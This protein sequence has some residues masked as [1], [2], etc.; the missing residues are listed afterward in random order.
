MFI[1]E[2]M[3][4]MKEILEP[5]LKLVKNGTCPDCD[6]VTFVKTKYHLV[7]NY[8]INIS[9][10]LML[11]AKGLSTQSHP[12]IKRLG[13]YRQLLGQ[14]QSGEENLLKEVAAIV[15]AVKEDKPLYS[16]SDGSQRSIKKK[17]SRSDSLSKLLI[18]QKE[19]MRHKQE[20]LSDSM[21]VDSMNEEFTDEDNFDTK[22]KYDNEDKKEQ[23]EENKNITTEE[24][25]RA[26]TYQMAKNRGLTPY[27]KKELRN[28]R[29]KHRKKY[30]KAKIRRR[31]AVCIMRRKRIIFILSCVIFIQRCDFPRFTR[32]ETFFTGEGS[33]KGTD[34]LRRRDLWY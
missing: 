20:E 27:R 8:C 15:K 25:K 17:S 10:Y 22:K 3:T 9:F 6:A 5:F 13:Q 32:K 23:N 14:L 34:T 4:E 12:V 28:P 30:H 29:V 26:I 11:K 33:E 31:G 24:E 19:M 18:C 2:R 16:V 7:L 1:T 21:D